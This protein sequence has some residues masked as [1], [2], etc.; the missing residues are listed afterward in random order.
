MEGF[1]RRDRCVALPALIGDARHGDIPRPPEKTFP[2]YLKPTICSS[3]CTSCHYPKNQQPRSQPPMLPTPPAAASSG[4]RLLSKALMPKACPALR[5]ART[6]PL[7]SGHKP[8]ICKDPGPEKASKPR[9]LP[10][11]TTKAKPV[12]VQDH[13]KV[14]EAE[15]LRSALPKN[16]KV[17]DG[18][19]KGSEESSEP[20][21][22]VDASK[23]PRTR[24]RSMSMSSI[25]LSAGPRK[26][27]LQGGKK[28]AGNESKA[29]AAEGAVSKR[30]EAKMG[31]E[32]PPAKNAVKEEAASKLAARRNK[33]K[34]LVGA[35][36]TAMSLHETEKQPSTQQ[37]EEVAEPVKS[38]SAAADDGRGPQE[39]KVTPEGEG[40]NQDG[41]ED[42]AGGQGE[43]GEESKNE[44]S[45]EEDEENKGREGVDSM[46]TRQ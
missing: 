3:H 37:Q 45:G 10:K 32:S 2:N 39:T 4:K 46:E 16:R 22:V 23:K 20:A 24:A 34:A 25:D 33:V 12:D 9:S 17:E 18:P 35:F 30:Q 44:A 26:L 13:A 41:E 14:L 5:A 7:P 31:K 27:S 38:R 6:P 29:A 42:T 43:V 1:L 36:E 11:A 19:I 8:A 21:D 15:A 40:Q 28:A